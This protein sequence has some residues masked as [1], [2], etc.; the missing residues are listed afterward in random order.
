MENTK[1]AGVNKLGYMDDISP[2]VL[3]P[4]GKKLARKF[5]RIML[6]NDKMLM[7]FM[8]LFILTITWFYVNKGR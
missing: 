6:K 2:V 8:A 3:P 4:I 1:P 7:Y 5:A